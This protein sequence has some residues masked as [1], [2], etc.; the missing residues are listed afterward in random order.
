M[1]KLND[2]LK[3][4]KHG[5]HYGNRL[6]LPFEVD[7]LKATLEKDIITDFSSNNKGAEYI[8]RDGY[9][10]VYFYSYDSLADVVTKYE[11]IKMI[12]VEKNDDIFDFKKHRFISIDILENHKIEIKEIDEDQIF[13][14]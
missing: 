12:V 3:S 11:L 8:I 13:V 5:L 14:E 4:N 10:E 7:V 2:V 1:S 6:L 9:T